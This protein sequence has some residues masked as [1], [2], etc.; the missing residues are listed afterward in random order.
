MAVLVS[1]G[2]KSLSYSLG[3]FKTDV[4]RRR[5][6]TDLR[7]AAPPTPPYVHALFRRTIR[8]YII[9]R[10]S[11]IPTFLGN[12][13]RLIRIALIGWHHDLYSVLVEDIEN[14]PMERSFECKH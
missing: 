8:G 10:G 5:T 3:F 11:R 6:M 13:L 7:S 1:V 12:D 14:I 4:Y 2:S 9:T